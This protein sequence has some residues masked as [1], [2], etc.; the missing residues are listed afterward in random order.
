MTVHLQSEEFIEHLDGQLA[1]PRTRHLQDCAECTARLAEWEMLASA[2]R[3]AGII[4]EPSPLF[5]DCFS[6]RVHAATAT[7]PVNPRAWWRRNWIQIGAGGCIG[8]LAAVALAVHL[9]IFAPRNQKLEARGPAEPRTPVF[10]E[11]F[12]VDP[13]SWDLVAGLAASV[14]F[15]E[16][17]DATAPRP[18]TTDDM[19][20]QL[21]LPQ[22]AEL[23]RLV[24][25]DK[26]SGE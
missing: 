11:T 3:D 20:T 2:I 16:L 9:G 12:V 10:D 4:P 15:D 22:R 17:R 26:L 24:K 21:T 8:V 13:A 5:W 6:K 14:P 7:E 18:G 25:L 23:V 1:P 19:V